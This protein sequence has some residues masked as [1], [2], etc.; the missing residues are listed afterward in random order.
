LL[1][2]QVSDLQAHNKI[3]GKYFLKEP[4]EKQKSQ[5]YFL[6]M[7]GGGRLRNVLFPISSISLNRV[8]EIVADLPLGNKKESQDVCFLS[9][10]KLADYLKE[11][12]PEVFKEGDILDMSG[13]RIGRHTGSINFTIGQRRG[14]NFPSDGKLYVVKKNIMNNTITLGKETDLYSD[15]FEVRNPVF[16][17][18]IKKGEHYRARI[19][20]MS[21]FE[22]VVILEV[23]PDSIIAGFESPVK[24][25]TPG[26]IGAF[27]QDDII[28]A[29]GFII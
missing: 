19:R 8:R 25:V 23:S 22:N 10:Y 14:T 21:S 3:D 4:Q 27:F 18:D 7:I 29:S 15:G 16:W 5:I 24:S 2:E 13:K 17:K 11:Y 1:S 12:I 26:Q 28:A 20:Y 6:S 9:G